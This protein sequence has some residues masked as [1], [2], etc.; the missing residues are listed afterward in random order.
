[1]QSFPIWT[2]N[3]G[4]AV[5]E[6]PGIFWLKNETTGAIQVGT[7]ANL[8]AQYAQWHSKR[9]CTESRLR[10]LVGQLMADELL[11]AP[12]DSWRFIVIVADAA[13]T[14]D[15]LHEGEVRAIKRVIDSGARCL[16]ATF[17]GGKAI[18]NLP[19]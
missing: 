13:L 19:R 16:N 4:A 8:R 2:E 5:P 1:M 6:L 3:H 11:S 7:A 14:L 12:Q 17:N 10:R 15:Q 9:R 18:Y